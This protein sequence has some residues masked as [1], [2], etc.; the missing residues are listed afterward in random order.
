M[1]ISAHI[2]INAWAWIRL[3]AVIRRNIVSFINNV[4]F[5]EETRDLLLTGHLWLMKAGQFA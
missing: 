3:L 2:N 5:E 1:Y 4:L